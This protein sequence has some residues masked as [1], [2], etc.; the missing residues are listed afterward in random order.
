MSA[1]VLSPNSSTCAAETELIARVRT[2]SALRIAT[3]S[4]GNAAINSDFAR[5]TPSRPP[6]RSPCASATSVTTPI[7]GCAMRHSSAISPSARIPISST[8]ISVLVGMFRIA[9]GK[10]C[11]LLKLRSFA[12]VD[13]LAAS[14]AHARS[15]VDVLP[16][17]PVMPITVP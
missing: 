3:P 11:S 8:A 1:S 10:P 4:D 14:A 7:F 9:V 6:T 15:L 16:T 13:L 12:H 2:S 17:D 5:A